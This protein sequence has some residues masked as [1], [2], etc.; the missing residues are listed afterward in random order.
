MKVIYVDILLTINL[1]VD[2]LLLFSVSRLGGVRFG[3]LRALL[4]ATIGAFYSLILFLSLPQGVLIGSRLLVSFLMIAATFERRSFRELLRLTVIFYVGSFL[5]SGVLTLLNSFLH[6]D[7]FFSENG[8]VYYEFSAWEIILSATAAFLIIELFH[9]LFQRGKTERKSLIRI[10]YGGK[11][12]VLKGFTDT[13]NNLTEPFSGDPVAVCSPRSLRKLVP[14][15]WLS[16][17]DDPH[18]S[19]ELGLRQIPC[20]T[21]SG[22]VLMPAF[23]PKK[24]E[25]EQKGECWEAEKIWVGLSP[26]A[27]DDTVLIGENIIFRKNDKIFSEVLS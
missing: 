15:E 19:T 9:R 6:A 24:M 23:R 22:T 4:G 18:L 7:S 27:P 14:E 2:Y 3:R 20:K 21:V 5:V 12:I 10:E 17:M 8:I 1:A 25:M 16:C 13:G 26:Y 11:T